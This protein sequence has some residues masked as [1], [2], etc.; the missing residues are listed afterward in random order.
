MSPN[1][2][3]LAGSTATFTCDTDHTSSGVCLTYQGLLDFYVIDVCRTKFDDKFVNRCNVTA[4][5]TDGP[6]T[7]TI[8]DVRLSDAGFYSCGDCYTAK[9]TT[10]LLVL[11]KKPKMSYTIVYILTEN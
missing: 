3:V 11:G 9:A 8:K 2:A 10:H 6:Y 4:H 5:S 1:S 7:L